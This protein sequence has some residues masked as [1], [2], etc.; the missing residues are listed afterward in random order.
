MIK[1]KFFFLFLLL[2]KINTFNAQIKSEN[3]SLKN[4]TYLD[5]KT[6]FDDYY[7][8]DQIKESDKIAQYFLQKSK[9]E[10]NQRQIAEGYMLMQ[11]NR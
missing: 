2:F 10:K 1:T 8:R 3:D 5:L 11:L 9:L 6:K 4:Y 7:Y